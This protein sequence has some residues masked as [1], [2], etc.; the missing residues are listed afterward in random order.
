MPYWFIRPIAWVVFHLLYIYF[1]GVRFEGRENVPK[2]GGVLITPNHISDADP[3]TVA[4]ALPRD[5]W[6]MAK[7]EIF[8]MKI[9]GPFSR[10]L[11][12]FPVKRYTADRAALRRAEDLLKQGEAVI[13]F[14]EGKLSPDGQVQP[15]LPGVLLIAKGAN[16]PIVPT[17]LI[18]T[19]L[20][21]PY[22]STVPRR[23]GKRTTVRFGPPVTVAELTGG[24]KGS[25]AMHRGAERLRELML[26][27]QRGEP[28]PEMAPVSSQETP[29]EAEPLPSEKDAETPRESERQDDGTDIERIAQPTGTSAGP[30]N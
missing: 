23:S 12:G 3:P 29:T 4:I 10:W 17:V 24:G 8:S 30:R 25:A 28:Y 9:I 15:L 18:G 20:I 1:G 2:K 13:I 22:G 7:E 21:I 19:D 14:P 16:V 11:H 5:A 27:L 26:A 6:V